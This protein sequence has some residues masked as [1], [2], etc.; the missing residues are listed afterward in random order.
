MEMLVAISVE[1]GKSR[2]E[3]VRKLKQVFAISGEE[4]E[5]YFDKYAVK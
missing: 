1:E 4:A 2:E 3:T 5:R